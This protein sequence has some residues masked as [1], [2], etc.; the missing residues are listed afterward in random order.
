MLKNN[1]IKW[2]VYLY[3]KK[4][5]TNKLILIDFNRETDNLNL[6]TF[7]N[8]NISLDIPILDF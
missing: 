5:N 4:E 7:I 8:N 1:V 3:I 6:K 2:L